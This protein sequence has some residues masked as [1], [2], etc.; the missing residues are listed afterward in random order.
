MSF[1]DWIES[2]STYKC[3]LVDVDVKD[4][5]EKTLNLSSRPYPG[6]NPIVIGDSIS[7]TERLSLDGRSG[8]TVGDIELMN[9]DGSIDS[10]LDYI[11]ANRSVKVYVG[12]VRF[13]KVDFELV[14]DGVTDDIDSKSRDVLNIKVRD[15]LQRLEFPLTENYLGGSGN[16]KDSLLPLCFG[17]VFNISPLLADEATLKYQYHQ[18]ATE[19]VIEVRDNGVPVGFTANNTTGTFVL[20]QDPFGQVTCSVQGDKPTNWNTTAANIINRI[21]TTYG[22]SDLR[23]SG[24]DIDSSNFNAFDLANPQPL[25]IYIDLSDT[26]LN[27]CNQ[28]AQSVGA[29]LMV[30]RLGKL[31]LHKV[32]LTPTGTPTEITSKD[33]I[34]GSLSV[35]Q[36]IKVQGSF[37]VQ[38]CKN[39][40][41]QPVLDTRIPAAHKDLLAKEWLE[42]KAENATVKSNYKQLVEVEAIPT[43]LLQE[44]DAQ[45]LADH[46]LSIYSTPRF[47]LSLT[48]TPKFMTM[49]LGDFVTITTNRFGLDS[50]KT[51]Q[52]VGIQINLGN[53]NVNLEVLI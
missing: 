17:E 48:V 40:T 14:L 44:S 3:V 7:M 12:D 53:G 52:V 50:G 31:Q 2:D 46:Y 25:G 8:F 47:I 35:A 23:F 45:D 20:T 36:K 21:V 13:D 29:Q 30:N 33:I 43:L 51:G 19:G 39:W 22:H 26:V 32:T 38:Y 28:I 41:V 16:N 5:A 49:N 1:Q 6:Y 9:A 18:G 24:G 11:W 27:V 15:K 37:K 4:G 10:Y 42:V 34:A